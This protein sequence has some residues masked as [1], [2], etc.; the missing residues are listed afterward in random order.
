MKHIFKFFTFSMM[1]CG[2]LTLAVASCKN[3]SSNDGE[4]DGVAAIKF[5]ATV[6]ID[7]DNAVD[8]DKVLKSKQLIE[9]EDNTEHIIGNIHNVVVRGD[10]IFAIDAYKDPGIYAYLTN[11]KQ[12][13]A[14]CSTGNGPGDI[15]SPQGLS[16]TADEVSTYNSMSKIIVIGK[17]GKYRR[18]IDT[19][20][21]TLSALLDSK[22]N[23]WAD[24]TNQDY[25]DD[26]VSW[27]AAS[28][29]EYETVQKVPE[30]LRGVTIIEIE[31]LQNLN[32]S[33][34]GYQPVMEPTI[35]TL[36]D[37]KASVRYNLDFNGLWPDDETMKSK[38]TG[39]AFAPMQ[40]YF[41]VIAMHFHESDRYFVL[42]FVH[43]KISYAHFLDKYTG[44]EQTVKIDNDVYSGSIY[45]TD[46][47]F[48]LKRS[49]DRLEIMTIKGI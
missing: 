37:G 6:S 12:L 21:M 32:D 23:V 40:R 22:G 8:M 34:I 16:V 29:T 17:D 20:I 11:G 41:P 9:L 45:V 5:P 10:T 18:S 30:M 28:A 43:D 4:D 14:Y 33:T 19:P 46:T 1:V 35:Y 15:S 48:Y 47:D 13:F 31:P 38:F 44:K 7:I 36:S 27:K 26:R 25:G 2:C 24:F 3:D 49:D 39:A 42:K